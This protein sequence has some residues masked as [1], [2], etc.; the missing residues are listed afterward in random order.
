M[1]PSARIIT[2]GLLSAGLA[3][4]G[5]AGTQK[6]GQ[7]SGTEANDDLPGGGAP[8]VRLKDPL[9]AGAAPLGSRADK[10]AV[11]ESQQKAYDRAVERWQKAVREGTFKAECAAIAEEFA[12]VYEAHR[13]LI[14]ARGNQAAVLQ[15]CGRAAEAAPIWQQLAEGPKP[16][17]MALSQLGYD[18]WLRGDVARAEALFQRAVE[19]DK[20]LGSVPARLNL[21]QLLREKAAKAR[22]PEERLRYAEP[23]LDHLRAVLAVDGS[24]LQAYATLTYFYYDLDYPEMARLVGQQAIWRAEEIATGKLQGSKA[25]MASDEKA[26]GKRGKKGAEAAAPKTEAA[27]AVR[28]TGYTPEMKK[29]LG[30]VYNTLGLVWLKKDVSQAIANFRKAVEMDP[31]LHEARM[32]LAALSLNYRNYPVAEENFRTVLAA[33]PKNYE[34]AIGLGVALRGNRKFEEA[35]Q[36]YLT[37]QKM[38]PQ[39]PDSYFNLGLLYQEYKGIDRP[40]LQKAQQFYRD[41]IS[42]ARSDGKRKEAQKRIKDI[43][44]TLAALDEAAK[45]Q[46]EAEEMQKKMEE[47]QKK[48]E[49]EMKKMQD[50]EKQQAAP[51][52]AAPQASTAPPPASAAKAAD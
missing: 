36:Q 18:A 42:R 40:A 17:A 27:P 19:M 14:E 13:T 52:A 4:L 12:D 16:Y 31:E 20:Q 26:A 29:S 22:S 39:H 37:A 10:R 35:E 6:L 11:T 28:G 3:T 50:Q 7:T 5:C 24:N 47:Q 41:F 25:P 21:A 33:Q 48:M 38:E 49:E 30:M 8:A 23:A 1:R 9:A 43:D 44:D 45:M 51:A 15:Q 46:K 34:A 32:N 2:A